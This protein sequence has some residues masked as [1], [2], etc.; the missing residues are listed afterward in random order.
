MDHPVETS[1]PKLTTYYCQ[2]SVHKF[3]CR[4]NFSS[5]K[6]YPQ[7][8]W[9]R[10]DSAAYGAGDRHP[11]IE[12]RTDAL[13]NRVN[14]QLKVQQCWEENMNGQRDNKGNTVIHSG[15]NSRNTENQTG[16]Q[17]WPWAKGVWSKGLGFKV[18]CQLFMN[19]EPRKRWSF[20]KLGTQ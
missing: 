19:W 4:A 8:V 15:Q 12:G 14:T 2:H 11:G 16:K 6:C 18:E 9:H 10:D 5:C 20:C 1:I 17:Q 7:R 13:E 3:A